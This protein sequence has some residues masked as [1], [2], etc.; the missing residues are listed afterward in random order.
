MV[1]EEQKI[2]VIEPKESIWP[3]IWK[4]IK[5]AWE[6]IVAIL[7]VVTGWILIQK[8]LNKPSKP[9]QVIIDH[10]AQNNNQI[11]EIQHQ[12]ETNIQ[13]EQQL[14]QE[15]HVIDQQIDQI[16]SNIQVQEQ[17]FQKE[18]Q[19]IIET[20]QNHQANIDYINKKYK[21]KTKQ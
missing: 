15:E 8:W 17:E 14:E 7:I 10:I 11:N 5:E 19:K 20:T 1:D 13:Q 6:W 9:E 2:E 12:V 4:F 18:E 21:R 3:K 16:Y